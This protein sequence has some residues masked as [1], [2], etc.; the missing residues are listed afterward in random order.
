MP[1]LWIV[2]GPNG[3]GK[4]TL[5]D[6]PGFSRLLGPGLIK[7]N[8]DVLTLALRAAN[9]AAT[10]ANLQAAREIDSQV[11][12]LIEERQ[13]FL[14][15]TVLSSDKYLD[16]IDRALELGFEVGLIYVCLREARLSVRRV[17]LRRERGGHD[18]PM[19]KVVTRWHRSIT[20]LKRIAPKMH[21]F[22]VF[23]NSDREGPILIWSKT[24]GAVVPHAPGRIHEIDD[25]LLG[26]MP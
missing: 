19:D 4:S 17:A 1:T 16:D 22:Y 26:L 7:L 14:V 5:V 2:A 10:D 20:M 24:A 11:A 13:S 12:R 25:A 23:D 9:P 15:E 18:V 3:S 21:R 8:A 6:C